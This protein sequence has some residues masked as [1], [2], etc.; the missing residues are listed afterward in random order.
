[1]VEVYRR[2]EGKNFY[3]DGVNGSNSNS[4]KFPNDAVKQLSTIFNR[5]GFLAGDKVYV[6]NKVTANSALTWNGL[7][8][9]NVTLYRYNGGHELKSGA[10]PIVGNANNDSYKGELLVANHNVS[11]TG[12]TLDGYYEAPPRLWSW[13]AMAVPWNSLRAPCCKT[14]TI[15]QATAVPSMSTKAVR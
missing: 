2:G 7:N 6:V 8:Y 10:D 1:M 14:T 12:I 11:V 15:A 5:C 4:G 13:S 9:S 3:L